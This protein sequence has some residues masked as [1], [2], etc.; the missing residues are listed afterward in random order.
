M[1]QRRVHLFNGIVAFTLILPLNSQLQTS[2]SNDLPIWVY[3]SLASL[4][5]CVVL[6]A[7]VVLAIRIRRRCRQNSMNKGVSINDRSIVFKDY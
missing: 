2:P 4:A 5:A 7:I 3:I 6:F 1:S